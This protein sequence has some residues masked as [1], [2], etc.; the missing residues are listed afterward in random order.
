MDT[1]FATPLDVRI[2]CREN[3]LKDTVASG[4]MSGFLCVNIVML[5]RDHA[6]DFIAFC[7][8]NPR[9][10]P[11][12]GVVEAGHIDC[13]EFAR[14]LDLRTDLGSYDVIRDG[15]VVEHVPDV[16]ELFTDRT[17][18]LLIGSS[19]SFDGLLREKGMAPS[20]GPRLLLTNVQCE[21]AGPFHGPMCVTVRWPGTV[22]MLLSSIGIL[23]VRSVELDH[24]PSGDR[25]ATLRP[26]GYGYW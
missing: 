3:R 26:R 6:A 7:E 5:D 12:L 16:K 23:P 21:P 14:E 18:T 9:P 22:S 4:A 20:H 25:S 8:R 11:L 15:E 19:V 10:C 2:A 1:T 17:V 13:P 24:T